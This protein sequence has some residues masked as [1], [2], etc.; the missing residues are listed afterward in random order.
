[1]QQRSPYVTGDEKRLIVE[2]NGVLF[3]YFIR[4]LTFVLDMMGHLVLVFWGGCT[5]IYIGVSATLMF[6]RQGLMTLVTVHI[7]CT[8]WRS[9]VPRVLLRHVRL[10]LV[11][12][13]L[14]YV[15]GWRLVLA[16]NLRTRRIANRGKLN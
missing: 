15:A 11:V 6:C 8:I 9:W 2:K 7:W 10:T 1:M 3:E 13:K 16:R 12:L 5:I 14:L 4:G